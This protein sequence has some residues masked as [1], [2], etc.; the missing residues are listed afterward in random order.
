M[1]AVIAKYVCSRFCYRK[2]NWKIQLP[3][4]ISQTYHTCTHLATSGQQQYNPIELIYKE[5]CICIKCN[6]GTY[7]NTDLNL[8]I[9]YPSQY[10]RLYTYIYR[11]SGNYIRN[12]QNES[13]LCGGR[14]EPLMKVCK[15]NTFHRHKRRM[16]LLNMHLLM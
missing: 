1:E 10:T 14:E 9:P 4:G 5:M 12:P 15:E 8:Y 13:Y 16:Y 11:M 7:D 2:I 3:Y 6:K